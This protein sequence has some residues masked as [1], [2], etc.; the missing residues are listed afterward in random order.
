MYEDSGSFMVVVWWELTNSKTTF[1]VRSVLQTLCYII[2]GRKTD[3]PELKLG[4][5]TNDPMRFF[6]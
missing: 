2:L 1:E 5:V 4:C 3:Q 6:C